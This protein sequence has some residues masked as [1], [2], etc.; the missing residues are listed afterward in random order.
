MQAGLKWPTSFTRK[1]GGA[2]S[3][4]RIGEGDVVPLPNAQPGGNG[5]ER[6]SE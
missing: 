4:I 2:H 5:S 1:S 6:G 3:P